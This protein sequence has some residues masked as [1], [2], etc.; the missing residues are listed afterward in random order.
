MKLA[1]GLIALGLVSA[2]IPAGVVLGFKPWPNGDKDGAPAAITVREDRGPPAV[3][4]PGAPPEPP[5][6]FQRVQA[7][8]PDRAGAALPSA[9]ALVPFPVALPAYLPQ[10]LKLWNVRATLFE[11]AG[12]KGTIELFY[13][14]PPDGTNIVHIIQSTAEGPLDVTPP[15]EPGVYPIV[16]QKG[17]LTAQ[18][19]EWRYSVLVFPDITVLD[20]DTTT[21]AGVWISADI[22]FIGMDEGTALAELQKVLESLGSL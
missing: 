2:L 21:A 16:K 9:T 11:A 5:A 17:A 14:L 7:V 8:G 13:I 12:D 20:A 22:G 3:A 19:L 6:E 18:G 10:G 15:S 1:A 4:G